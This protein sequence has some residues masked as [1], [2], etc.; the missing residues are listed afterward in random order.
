MSFHRIRDPGAP[1][2]SPTAMDECE[3]VHISR[4][5]VIAVGGP[6]ASPCKAMMHRHYCEKKR[7]MYDAKQMFMHMKDQA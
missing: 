3:L 4:K 7:L 6:I 5:R 2:I 1:S